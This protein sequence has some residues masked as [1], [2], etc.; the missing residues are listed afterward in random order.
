METEIEAKFLDV[1]PE[2]L[3]A[4]LA[5]VGAELIHS[6]RLMR[7]E[8]FDYPDHRLDKVNGWVRL[9]DEGDQV[10]L[11]YKQLYDR[12][13][14]GMKEVSI[15]VD[16]YKKSSKF[17]TAIGLVVRSCQESKR[18]EWRIG[19][20]EITIDTWPWVPP[21]LEIEGRDEKSVRLVAD[22]LGFNWDD[23]VHG[24]VEIVYQKH[25]DVTEQEVDDWKEIIFSPVPDWLEKKRK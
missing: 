16:D 15:T 11:S 3:R 22:Q 18:E 7:R 1:D 12:T 17:I 5:L 23:A 4:K 14:H 19:R 6:E 9:R 13:L 24:S 21:F 25:Y 2:K 10:T 8:N 20:T